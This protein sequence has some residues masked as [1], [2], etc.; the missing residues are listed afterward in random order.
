MQGV[1]HL[2]SKLTR[3]IPKD[4][5][6]ALIAILLAVLIG[7]F[8][9]VADEMLEG[10]TTQFDNAILLALRHADN[11]SIP[12]GPDWLLP[13]VKDITALGGA[14]IVSLVVLATS[15]YFMLK[16]KFHM[17]FF[18][19]VSAGGGAV[20]MEVLKTFFNRPRPSIVPH[21]TAA[22][23]ASFPS[24]H[25]MFSAIVYLTIAAIL[26]KT[27]KSYRL[28]VYYVSV[29][30][31]LTMLVGFS[32]IYLGVHYPTDVLA[33]W[34]AGAVWAAFTYLIGDWLESRGQIEKEESAR[35]NE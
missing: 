35:E 19:L 34:C 10:D 18:L 26:A 15:G 2:T 32:R 11:P 1:R 23:H 24:G 20:A 33:G 7:G 16:H 29:G 5:R 27:T 25:S 21:L 30:L 12:I 17:I 8:I 13:V 4:R 14:A 6:F 28:K 3:F 9:S 22:T 31:F